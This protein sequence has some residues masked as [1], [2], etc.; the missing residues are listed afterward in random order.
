MRIQGELRSLSAFQAFT[1]APGGG[2]TE[3]IQVPLY[4]G[5]AEFPEDSE[6]QALL[7]TGDLQFYDRKDVPEEDRTLLGHVVCQEISGLSDAGLLPP[8]MSTGVILTGDLY[9][10]ACLLRRGGTGDVTPVWHHFSDTFRWVAGV[11]GNHDLFEEEAKFT[12]ALKSRDNIYPL[13]GDVADVDGLKIGGISGIP[14]M[15]HKPWRYSDAEWLE[16]SELL[17]MDPLDLFVLHCGPEGSK[18][19]QRGTSFINNQLESARNPPKL[20][21]F[22]HCHWKEPLDRQTEFDLLNVDGAVVLLTRSKDDVHL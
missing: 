6:L 3:R 17:F 22:G 12:G 21:T 14:G 2:R 20:T 5:V 1:C 9:A 16:L 18:Q 10:E 7:L 15:N 13:H 4:H 8:R 11:A 19:G